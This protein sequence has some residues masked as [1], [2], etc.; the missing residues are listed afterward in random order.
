MGIGM[1]FP[2]STVPNFSNPQSGSGTP[3]G[4]KTPRSVP[5]FYIDTT[6]PGFYMAMGATNTSWACIASNSIA[7]TDVGIG[8]SPSTSAVVVQDGSGDKMQV[9][10]AVGGILTDAVGDTLQVQGGIFAMT[11]SNNDS[12]QLN[13][14]TIAFRYSGGTG[15]FFHGAVIV[16]SSLKISNTATLFAGTA[17]PGAGTGANGDIYFQNNNAINAGATNWYKKAAGAWTGLV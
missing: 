5:D 17:A 16:Q 11:D 9:S 8:I 3:N 2:Q 10:T 13:A 7:G 14:G 15:A 12:I 4:H 1:G 6:T